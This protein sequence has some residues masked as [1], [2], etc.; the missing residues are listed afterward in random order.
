[1]YCDSNVMLLVYLVMT[2]NLYSTVNESY[3]DRSIRRSVVP[4]IPLGGSERHRDSR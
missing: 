3:H 4:I 2:I 1:M